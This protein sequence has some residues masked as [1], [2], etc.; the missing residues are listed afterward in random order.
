MVSAGGIATSAGPSLS[1]DSV[2]SVWVSKP[3]SVTFH[4]VQPYELERLMQIEKP[5]SLAIA[6]ATTG[7]ALGLL[8][9]VQA[10]FA[11]ASDPTKVKS[12]DM[13][14]NLIYVILFAASVGISVIAW[15]NSFKGKSE[16]TKLLEE[17]RSRPSGPM[18][19]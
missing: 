3:E 18:S 2:I 8:P 11:S 19:A 4:W 12:V 1:V 5:Y 16:A 15:I 7:F 9:L 17:I 10:A 6:S 14:W 13:T